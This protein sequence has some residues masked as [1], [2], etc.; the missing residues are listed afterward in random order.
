[1]SP[2]KK[3]NHDN[4]PPSESAVP[5]RAFVAAAAA[6]VTASPASELWGQT[7]HAMYRAAVI[8]H[9]GRGNYGHGLDRVWLEVPGCQ[10]V[11]VADANPDGL[12]RAAKRLGDPKAYS[13]YR[14]MLDEAKPDLVS[15]APRWID[16]HCDMV[17][18]AAERGVRGI[19]QEK[20][21]CRT[22]E[23]ADRMVAACEKHGVKLAMAHQTRYSPK[24][25][26]MREMIQRGDLGQIVE[27]RARGKDDHRGG[28]EDLWVLGTHMFNLMSHFGGQPKSCFGTVWHQGR[29]ITAQDVV[30]GNEGIGPLAGHEV[31]A[32]Y[33]LANNLTGYFDSVRNGRGKQTR[34]GLRIFGSEGVFHLHE[35]GYLPAVHFL[36][37]SGWSPGRTGKQWIP[38]SSEGPGKPEPI[39]GGDLHAGNIAAV[40][41]L[42]ASIEEDRLPV[43]NVYEARAATEMIVAV[44]ESQR[45]GQPVTFPL[46]TRCNPLTMLG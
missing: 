20:P 12:A 33:R 41:D 25:K 44:F 16:E 17:L 6:A 35:T 5:R 3:T 23:E 19:Y 9:T 11:A 36:P 40:K 29:P 32:T 15:V 7:S 31:H 10:I 26:V 13:D 39:V 14:K 21:M 34:F 42:I 45:V 18:A 28:G 38:V 30:D 27:I 46:Q 1:M 4:H 37:D 24:L 2:E 43:S 8:G 22:L